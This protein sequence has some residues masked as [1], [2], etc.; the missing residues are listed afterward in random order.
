MPTSNNHAPV[1]GRLTFDWVAENSINGFIVGTV[2]AKDEDGDALTFKLI[3]NADGRFY[4]DGND[5]RVLDGS[6]FNDQV[7]P[8]HTVKVRVTDSHGESS[9]QEFTI[10]VMDRDGNPPP[11]PENH[12]PDDL[13]VWAEDV[14]ETA[15]GGYYVGQIFGTDPDGDQ[16]A[17]RI[18]NQDS[19]F[20]I[21]GS[22]I[23][24]RQD[25][26][27]DYET[28]PIHTI[29]VESSDGRGG[30]LTRS[31]DIKVRDIQET[32]PQNHPPVIDGLSNYW[33]SENAPDGTVIG[34][35]IAH[36]PDG[37]ML[38]YELLDNS[39]GRF[40]LEGDHVVVAD[41]SRI[42]YEASPFYDIKIRVTDSQGASD[43]VT[44]MISVLDVNENPPPEN[45]APEVE[46]IG[47]HVPENA[48][49]GTYVGNIDVMDPDNDA[50]SVE[51]VN[52]ADGR[53]VLNGNR[54]LV[55]DPSKL[56][57]E[58]SASHDIWVRVTDSRGG[59]TLKKFIIKV[60]DVD[61]SDLPPGNHAPSMVMLNGVEV[62]ENAETGTVVGYLGAFD[63]DG[64][65]LTFTLLD[66]ADGRFK[67][68]NNRVVVADGTKLDYETA[69]E[70]PIRV[71]VSDGQGGIVEAAFI[72]HVRDIAD[73]PPQNH[74]PVIDG[75]MGDVVVE[76]APNG[77][78]VG[79]VLAFDP[80]G[81][82][83][84][85]ELLDSDG[86]FRI[87]DD[88]I[89]V[90]DGSRLDYETNPY[91]EVKVRVTD[92][93]GLSDTKT[94]TISVKDVNEDGD[95][96]PS[97][98][99]APIDL[100]LSD[101][102]VTENSDNG[103]VVGVLIGKD[104]DSGDSLSYTLLDDAGGRFAIVDDELVVKD[105]SRLDHE[106]NPYHT[107][108][109]RVMDSHGQSFEKTFTIQVEDQEDEDN[110][111]S[112]A[113]DTIIGGAGDDSFLGG[114]GNDLITGGNGNDTL[115]GG[116]GNDRLFGGRGKDIISG[117]LGADI[118]TGG[119]GKDVFV[120]DAKLGKGNIDRITD[121][122]VKD[123]T[124]HLAKAIFK[125]A[126]SKGGLSKGA[127]WAGS[128]AHDASD[129]VI[130]DPRN[131][132]LY[133]DADGNGAKEAVQIALLKR[134]LDLTAKD[135]LIF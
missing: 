75:I 67:I 74:A 5:L 53:F 58:A 97:D 10:R 12:N 24:L 110:S 7:Q 116:A 32:P 54:L 129:R 121:F 50:V 86:R 2:Q 47:G 100:L 66:N 94:F 61:E 76:N 48:A 70:H 69:H 27:L 36:D 127:F 16:L 131:G 20:A 30:I 1:I 63:P 21:I 135:F 52:N 4:M 120:F 44:Y 78:V 22:T 98:N 62:K 122:S 109:A 11:P 134:G 59:E 43:T 37:Q 39:D 9:E 126:G 117:G 108:R 89:I 77:L 25:A 6:R 87:E 19:P 123:D 33:I 73:Q 68:E 90:A 79:R 14:P 92:S 101:S 17:Y 130:Y 104:P 57:Y 18:V 26:V 49:F 71:Q 8:T 55:A 115:G 118:L 91:H 83:L 124:I 103:T 88:R 102:G 60:D 81:G 45:H 51:L 28:K 106:A 31:F 128:E 80:D 65:P 38:K 56:D 132:K 35:V 64:D 82:H 40:R 42:D 34:R 99:H 96:P 119:A 111:G 84:K 125:A 3:D 112:D 13:F 105:S 15:Q 107:I 29:T 72:I 113:N 114:L 133:Y 46:L 85:Y 95:P 93:Q 41:G 23:V